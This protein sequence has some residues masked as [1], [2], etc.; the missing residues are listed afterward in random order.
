[1]VVSIKYVTT[2]GGL[3]GKSAARLGTRVQTD[4]ACESSSLCKWRGKLVKST[5]EALYS[6]GIIAKITD[7]Y[8]LALSDFE[9]WLLNIIWEIAPC[10]LEPSHAEAPVH[11]YTIFMDFD[12]WP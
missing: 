8:G 9:D 12:P 4:I 7:A 11:G 10:L 3:K 5:L 2:G 6:D 1:M